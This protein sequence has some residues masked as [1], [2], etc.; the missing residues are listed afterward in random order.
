MGKRGQRHK[1]S[2]EVS[3]VSVTVLAGGVGGSKLVTGL[4]PLLDPDKLMVIG[5]VGDDVNLHGL[6]ISP[7][8]DILTYSL[9]G[10]VDQEK[11][12]G[13]K[14]DT[15]ETLEALRKLGEETWFQLGNRDL[16]THILRTHLMHKGLRATEIAR[17]I[18]RQLEVAVRIL[19]ATDDE[20]RTMV[21]TDS[22]WLNFQE[23]LVRERCRP[24]IREIRYLGS[25]KARPSREVLRAIEESDLIV[26]APSNP[27]ASIGP[28]LAVPGIREALAK[29][30]VRKIAVSPIVGGRSLKGPSDKMMQ[31]LDLE[32]SPVG[33]ASYYG[34]LIDSLVIDSLDAG[35]EEKLRKCGLDV[36]TTPTIMKK[37]S[38][39]LALA[40]RLLA[41]CRVEVN[42]Q[43]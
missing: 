30:T 42:G 39:R 35:F 41:F 23:Y 4:A 19:P 20:V 13:F 11:G 43:S 7:D 36:L 32:L 10:M 21:K 29:T 12:W 37:D 6:W 1:E 33:I 28:I 18:T 25:K 31:S 38:D 17:R 2:F 3:S 26:I 5:N 15:F 34:S 27:I 8:I 9:A 40:Q 14:N 24:P 16:A 22:G